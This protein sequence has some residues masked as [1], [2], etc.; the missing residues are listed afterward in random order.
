[1]DIVDDVDDEEGVSAVEMRA[2]V[3]F[4]PARAVCPHCGYVG[5][6]AV[7][8]TDASMGWTYGVDN[9]FESGGA[10]WQCPGCEELF[11]VALWPAD[12]SDD[13]AAAIVDALQ[14]RG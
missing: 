6:F 5:K 3:M 11:L 10:D 14:G 2:P 7:C 9:A 4:R 12:C 8:W 1:M 13:E